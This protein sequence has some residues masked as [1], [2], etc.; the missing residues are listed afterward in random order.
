MVYLCTLMFAQLRGGS[1][2][3]STFY[4]LIGI[5]GTDPYGR[6]LFV[7][8]LRLMSAVAGH[9]AN[10]VKLPKLSIKFNAT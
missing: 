6:Y 8:L 1:R 4:V 2:L 7:R 9:T 10:E 5:I 3:T